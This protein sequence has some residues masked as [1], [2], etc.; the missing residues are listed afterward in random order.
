MVRRAGAARALK[1]ELMRFPIELTTDEGRAI[2]N[3]E[4]DWPDTLMGLAA[5][6]V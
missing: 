5:D 6:L 3:E 1:V 2:N 4:P